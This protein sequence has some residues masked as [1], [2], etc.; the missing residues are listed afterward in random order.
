MLE[1]TSTGCGKFHHPEFRLRFDDHAAAE[2]DARELVACL[3]RHVATRRLIRSGDSF[4]YG[5]VDLHFEQVGEDLLAV[6]EPDFRTWPIQYTDSVTHSLCHLQWQKECAATLS[7][8]GQATPAMGQTAAICSRIGNNSAFFMER[9]SALPPSSGWTISCAEPVHDHIHDSNMLRVS[10]YEIVTRFHMPIAAFLGLPPGTK[11][12]NSP[13]GL[14]IACNGRSHQIRHGSFLHRL[15][16]GDDHSRTVNV[17][18]DQ[19]HN[20]LQ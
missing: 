13:R 20:L 4:S 6:Q 10:L 2:R 17:L 9:H 3:E 18:I 19:A 11:V 16:R 14:W 5:W 1:I 15:I 12:L 8:D 7:I